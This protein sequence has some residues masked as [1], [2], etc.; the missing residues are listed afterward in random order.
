MQNIYLSAAWRRLLMLN[1]RVDPA[2]LQTHVPAGTELDIWNGT[3]YVSVVGFMFMNTRIKGIRVPGHV[4]FEE[5]NLRFYVRRNDPATGWKRGV[6]FIREIVP[7]PAIAWVANTI[8]REHYDWRPMAHRW[9][10]TADEIEV[11]YAWREKGAWQS[12]GVQADAETVPL[13]AG[14]EAEFITEHYWGYARRGDAQTIEYQ[15]EHPSWRMH[16]IRN[17]HCEI[18]FE[19]AYG[20]AFAHLSKEEPASIFLAE[21]SDIVVRERNL[22][23]I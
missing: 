16:P 6:V 18:D 9:Q 15:V 23:K 17:W 19:K 10:D 14:S 13:K 2:I 20:S 11:L 22:L 12:F 5:I 8:Y 1:Y 21:G 3:C 4:N 7:R